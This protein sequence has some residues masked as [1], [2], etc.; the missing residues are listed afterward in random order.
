M[1][2][3][4][5]DADGLKC[6]QANVQCDLGG[7]DSA[8]ADALENFRSEVKPGGGSGDRT[9]LLGI[10]GLVAL[11][12]ARRI[13]TR[14]VGRKRDVPDA[15]ENSEETFGTFKDR[16]EADAAFAEFPTCH[17]LGLQF[18]MLAKVQ[19]LSDANLAAGT[20]QAFPVVGVGQRFG[21][22]AELRCGRGGSRETL[23]SAGLRAERGH[24]GGGHRG[25][26]EKRAC[27]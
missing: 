3:D 5:L 26:R 21:A 16:L 13:G 25:G 7:F 18:I 15:I 6:P 1:I 17:D 2:F 8:L 27:C 10:D 9:G 12:I 14:D 11:A 20:N 22:S 19:A 24:R 23:D 4:A